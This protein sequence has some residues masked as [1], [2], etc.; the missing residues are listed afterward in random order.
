MNVLK[1]YTCLQ[2]VLASS[3]SQGRGNPSTLT[4]YKE[5]ICK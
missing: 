3:L 5:V 1:T 2:Y 4:L